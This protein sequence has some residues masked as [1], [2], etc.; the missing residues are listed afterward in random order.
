VVAN[1]GHP[2]DNDDLERV[3]GRT[4]SAAFPRVMRDP[5][6]ES[7][8]LLVAGER[9]SAKRLRTAAASLPRGLRA[10]AR[11]EAAKAGPRLAGGTIYTDDRAPVEWLVDRSILGYAAER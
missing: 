10:L 6:D 7:N 11:A 4:L 5:F 3:I 2:E 8:T 1:V 9:A